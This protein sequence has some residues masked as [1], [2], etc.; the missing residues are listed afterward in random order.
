ML[1]VDG[2]KYNLLSISQLCDERNIIIFKKDQCI[3]KT[4]E[5]EE[6]RF[7]IQCHKNMYVLQLKELADQDVCLVA[8][9]SDLLQLWHR[10]L[11][12]AS[13]SVIEKLQRLNIVEGLPKLNTKSEVVCD[14]C[15]RGKQIKSSFKSKIEVST[16]KPL[17][18]LHM[19]MFG[20]ILTV[21]LG[22]KYY[23]YVIVDDY[24]RYT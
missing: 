8:N 17:E 6:T 2:L 13:A 11:G 1:L 12:H 3:I 9:K 18:L 23:G 14:A 16:T 19:D 10:R 5:S 21:S 7:I 20:P 4:L 22:G 15:V 24:S